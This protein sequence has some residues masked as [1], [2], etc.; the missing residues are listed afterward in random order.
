M[1]LFRTVF[2]ALFVAALPA[3]SHITAHA[4]GTPAQEIS[5]KLQAYIKCIN[6]ISERAYQSQ[7]RYVGWAGRAAAI[8]AKAKN[9]LGL[10]DIYDP[11][12]CA[13][14]VKAANDAQPRHPELEAAGTGYV[15]ATLALETILKTANDYYD[16]GNYKDDKLA[17]GKEMH[18]KL[19]AAYATFDRA[20][21]ALRNIVERLNDE[22]QAADLADIEKKEGRNARYL[23]QAMMMKAKSVVRTKGNDDKVDLPKITGAL[24]DYET[25]VKELEEYAAKNKT[26]K[27]GSM[28]VSNAKTFLVSA[29]EY[30]RRIRD[31]VPFNEGERMML[32]QAGAGW[33]VQGSLPRLSRDYN[34][35]VEAYNRQ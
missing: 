2:L 25:A 33:M 11:A 6:R 30:M 35:L 7:E 3:T 17:K 12:D 23:I 19:L 20:D 5:E 14:G 34:Q 28:L 18:P 22:K 29:K 1:S 13:K 32:S 4:A 16:Q 26:E 31:K 9:I 10:Y 15:D 21:T 8:N 27:I 24:G